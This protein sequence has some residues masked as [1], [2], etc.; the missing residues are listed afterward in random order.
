[1][2]DHHFH[3]KRS[4][5]VEH[6]DIMYPSAVPFVLVHLACIAAFWT[7]V[8]HVALAIGLA[9]YWLR[10]FAIGAGYHRYFS[11]RAYRTGR[12]F[13]FVLAFLSQSSAQKSVLEK[14]AKAQNRAA[15]VFAGL[16]LPQLPTRHEIVRRASAMFAETPSMDIIV[17]RAQALILNTI[18]ARL[19]TVATV[20]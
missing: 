8:T 19:S 1:M 3:Q 20:H 6:D 13:Q 14:L 11:H 7:G 16:Y 10:I 17:S 18:G 12:V 15:D 9:L 2:S 4:P 5:I